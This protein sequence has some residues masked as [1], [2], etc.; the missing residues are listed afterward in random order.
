MPRREAPSCVY[1]CNVFSFSNSHPPAV[2]VTKLFVQRSVAAAAE[3]I[4]AALPCR[5]FVT[6]LLVCC[7]LCAYLFR[8]VCCVL[9]V[10]KMKKK[11]EGKKKGK[12]ISFLT[13]RRFSPCSNPSAHHL[14]FEGTARIVEA[15]RYSGHSTWSKADAI[16]TYALFS[17]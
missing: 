9:Y 3:T 15:A 8:G 7:T 16:G 14:T 6:R 2:A 17:R 4:A 11:R 10:R 13:S 12:H 5:H 1:I